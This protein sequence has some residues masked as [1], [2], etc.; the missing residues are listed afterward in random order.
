VNAAKL[1][2]SGEVKISIAL[3]LL[4]MAIFLPIFRLAVWGQR[5]WARWV[6]FVTFILSLPLLFADRR[7]LQPGHLP[8]TAY[9]FAGTLLQA[10]GFY[11]LFTGDAQPWFGA[12][13]SK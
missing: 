10:V 4:L 9:A 7:M 5:N 3:I 8:L 11:W 2:W 13:N 1:T 6:L 12:K